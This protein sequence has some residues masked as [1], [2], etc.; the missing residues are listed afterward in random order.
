VAAEVKVE[1]KSV[2]T[3][4]LWAVFAAYTLILS[5]T[6]AVAAPFSRGIW[7]YALLDPFTMPLVIF[8]IL[9]L[10]SRVVRIPLTPQQLALVYV[11]SAMAVAFCNGWAPY[12]V[13]HNAVAFRLYLSPTHPATWAVRNYWIFGPIISDPKE[14]EPFLKGGPCPWNQWAPFLAWMITWTVLWILFFVSW[15]ALLYERFMEVERLPFPASLTGT[16]QIELITSKE[17]TP[18]LKFFLLGVLIGVLVIAPFVATTVY[19]AIPDIYGWT[20][21]PFIPW[22]IGVL[23]FSRTPLG[24]AI[25]VIWAF[26][27]NPYYYVMFYLAPIRFSFTVWVFEL[28]I[29]ILSQIA[30]YMGYYSELPTMTM[31]RDAF[32]GGMPFKWYGVF[33]GAYLGLFVLWL[34]L[35]RRYFRDIFLREAPER[36]IPAKLGTALIVGSTILLIALY[37]AAGTHPL[38]GPLIVLTMWL[39]FMSCIRVYGNSAMWGGPTDWP[40]LPVF[41]RYLYTP[42]PGY[43]TVDTVK[44]RPPDMVVTLTLGNIWTGIPVGYIAQPLP[45]CYKIGYDAK[46]HPRDVTK[47]FV[48][49]A[50][51]SAIVGWIVS[52]WIAYFLGVLNTPMRIRSSW[53]QGMFPC[54]RARVEN[55]FIPEPLPPYVIAGFLLILIVSYLSYRFVWWPLD[56]TGVAFSFTAGATTWI[57]PALLAWIVKRLVYRIG[58]AK[59]DENVATP[60]AVGFLVGYNFPILIG[61]L[62]LMAQLFMPK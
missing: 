45:L 41:I 60:F 37:T 8:F 12:A 57:L 18:K 14:M 48:T 27:V 40:Q 46:V 29:V 21:A 23:D 58:G 3:P 9:F 47:V 43:I 25:P 13:L 30:F 59:L 4:R 36:A 44:I 2:L 7:V 49:S 20:K 51:I 31:R 35:N 24:P 19:P 50:T 62:I 26:P 42:D 22:F 34:A 28:I 53:W 10:A 55:S 17:P 52:V 33:I 1:R 11:A 15:N 6:C 5:F 54:P 39:I 38:G 16:L 32:M 56:P 61:S